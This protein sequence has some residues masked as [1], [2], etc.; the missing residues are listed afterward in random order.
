M[1]EQGEDG[2]VTRAF[3]PDFYLPDEDLYIEVTVMKQSLVT[4]K[5]RKLRELKQQYPRRQR[6]ALLPAR[7]RAPRPAISA[8]TRLIDDRAIGEIYLS[9]AEI[10][11]RVTELGAEIAADYDGLEPLL[12][13]P[14]K[15]S[16]V[17]LADLSRA[18]PIHHAIDVIELAG[19][20]RARAAVSGF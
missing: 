4:R 7:S 1:L 16:A 13:A 18:L 19:Y 17:F 20:G 14:L 11:T 5:N 12:V 15:S 10:A 6:Q 3:T 9:A 2:R 8:E